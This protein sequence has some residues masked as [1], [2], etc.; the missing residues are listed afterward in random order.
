MSEKLSKWVASELQDQ[1]TDPVDKW[2]DLNSL[3]NH[4]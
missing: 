4:Y 1:Y 2:V 3:T